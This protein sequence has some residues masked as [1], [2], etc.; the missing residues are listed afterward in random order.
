MKSLN[1]VGEFWR[2]REVASETEYKRAFRNLVG[3]WSEVYETRS[4]GGVGYPDVQLLV[5]GLL[6]PVEVKVGELVD[7]KTV[8][9]PQAQEFLRPERVRPSQI[10]WHHEFRE[11]GGTAFVLVCT[12]QVRAMNAWVAPG[13]DRETLS[14]WRVGWPL[15]ACTPWVEHGRLVVDLNEVAKRAFLLR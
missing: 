6:L 8:V 10:S 15:R 1:M 5:G 2:R 9:G 14:Q 11:A 12:G 13:T 7:P 3:V 4:G